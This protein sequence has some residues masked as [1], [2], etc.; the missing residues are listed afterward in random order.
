MEALEVHPVVLEALDVAELL[1]ADQPLAAALPA[2]V[3][4]R[5]RKAARLEVGDGLEI[6]LDELGPALDEAHRPALRRRIP[7]RR[8]RSG[9]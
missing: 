6:L 3:E 8:S 5:D 9:A 7:S 1:V 2:P 4:G